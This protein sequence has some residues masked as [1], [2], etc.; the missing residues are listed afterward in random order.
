MAIDREI[1]LRDIRKEKGMTQ[2]ELS[3]KTGIAQ[4]N[5][6]NLERDISHIR[7]STLFRLAAALGKK[8]TITFE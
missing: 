7:L 8:V 3:E 6:S 5:I 1:S 4:G 2:K